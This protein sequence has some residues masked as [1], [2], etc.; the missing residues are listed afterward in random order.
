NRLSTCLVS[1]FPGSP[2]LYFKGI[3]VS[4]IMFNA[5]MGE[6]CVGLG[7]CLI[8]Y[9]DHIK[10]ISQADPG[11]LPSD[12]DVERLNEKILEELHIFTKLASA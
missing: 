3:R 9:V 2:Q 1:N 6:G 5:G 10:L 4:D 7:F 12:A 8:S 11:V